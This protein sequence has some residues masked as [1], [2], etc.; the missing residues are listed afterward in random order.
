M[1][2]DSS[3]EDDW[4]TFSFSDGSWPVSFSA[5]SI[6]PGGVR[7]VV[8]ELAEVS[9]TSDWEVTWLSDGFKLEY[10][11]ALPVFVMGYIPFSVSFR[12]TFD[13]EATYAENGYSLYP[14]GY[15]YGMVVLD[16]G[17]ILPRLSDSASYVIGASAFTFGPEGDGPNTPFAGLD[18]FDISEDDLRPIVSNMIIDLEADTI[19]FR[20]QRVISDVTHHIQYATHLRDANW[21]IVHSFIPEPD[22]GQIEVTIPLLGETRFF[23]RI[24]AEVQ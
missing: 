1:T 2:V 13:F 11:G 8:P 16:D 21:V 7:F 18:A 15:V 24:V 20:F 9:A 12:S 14:N 4:F 17:R 3:F 23:Y 19:T 5:G 6:Y 10:I 22:L